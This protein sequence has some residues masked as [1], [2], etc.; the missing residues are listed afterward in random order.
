MPIWITFTPLQG[1]SLLIQQ[2]NWNGNWTAEIFS[3]LVRGIISKKFNF[4][5]HSRKLGKNANLFYLNKIIFKVKLKKYHA[6]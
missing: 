4:K 1:G 2:A 6:F 3:S 5:T